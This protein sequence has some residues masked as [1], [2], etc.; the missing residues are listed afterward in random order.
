MPRF[1]PSVFLPASLLVGALALAPGSAAPLAAQAVP[2][3]EALRLL[4]A[5]ADRFSGV[6][7][8]C[9]DFVQEIRVPLLG[10]ER[11]SRGR[12]CQRRPNLFRMDFLDPEGDR[13]VADGRH[14]WLYYPSMSPGQVVRLPVDPERGGLDFFREFLGDPA[15]TYQVGAGE[16][17]QVGG[18]ATLRIPLEPTSPR[19]YRRATVWI[20]RD[21]RMIRQIEVEEEN[22]SVRRVTLSDLRV[23]PP[24]AADHFE[25]APPA[26]VTVI[27]G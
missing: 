11:T 21:S 24:L 17:E 2:A 5:A 27:S 12:L 7:A 8:V 15:A 3:D 9:A 13:V 19:G 20:D 16:N 1:T 23:D 4:E 14:F 25:F 10:E 18:F 22:G 26:G 6:D